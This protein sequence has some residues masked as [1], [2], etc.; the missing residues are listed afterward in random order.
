M[1]LSRANVAAAK[2]DASG[3]VYRL[4]CD[5]IFDLFHIGHMKMLEQAKKALGDGA[6]VHLIAGV[7]SD[8][9]THKYK[10]K[11]VMDHRT[12]IESVR[13]CKW[14]VHTPPHTTPLTDTDARTH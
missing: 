5:G 7:N 13:H 3:R 4:Y 11:T 14:H 12:R 2:G 1:R 10:G 6:R 9:D 8:A